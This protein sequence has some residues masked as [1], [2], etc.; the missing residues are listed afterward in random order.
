MN[1]FKGNSK[2]KKKIN[3]PKKTIIRG[4]S[5]FMRKFSYKDK[6]GSQTK[7]LTV[8]NTLCSNLKLIFGED[9]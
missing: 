4:A 3:T 8:S 6:D 5:I 7:N 1:F 9:F 2:P